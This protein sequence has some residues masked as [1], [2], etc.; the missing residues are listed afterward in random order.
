MGGAKFLGRD[1]GIPYSKELMALELFWYWFIGGFFLSAFL[2]ILIF[3]EPNFIFPIF[4][5]LIGSVLLFIRYIKI[6]RRSKLRE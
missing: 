6:E 4:F 2:S 5:Y 1:K 3:P